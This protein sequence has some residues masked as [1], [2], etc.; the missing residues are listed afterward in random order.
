VE[1]LPAQS[2]QHGLQTRA[3]D[4]PIVARVFNGFQPVLA[5]PDKPGLAFFTNTPDPCSISRRGAAVFF[6]GSVERLR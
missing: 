6:S 4:G 1:L 5:T 3:T 2:C